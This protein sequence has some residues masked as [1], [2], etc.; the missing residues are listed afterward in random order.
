MLN[1]SHIGQMKT[2]IE[3]IFNWFLL[4]LC[5]VQIAVLED[6]RKKLLQGILGIQKCFRG[7]KARRIFHEAKRGIAILQSCNAHRYS[8]CRFTGEYFSMSFAPPFYFLKT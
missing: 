7:K 2:T 3:F 6:M 1:V 4:L 5:D 8:F